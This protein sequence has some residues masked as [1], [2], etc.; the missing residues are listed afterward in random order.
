[1]IYHPCVPI[2]VETWRENVVCATREHA[3]NGEARQ[4]RQR[5]FHHYHI[6]LIVVACKFKTWSFVTALD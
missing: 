6:N 4:N 2:K 3:N 5:Q 1:L